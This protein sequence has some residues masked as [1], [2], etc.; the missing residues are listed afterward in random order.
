MVEKLPR[1]SEIGDQID[2]ML[3]K[4]AQDK[5]ANECEEENEKYTNGTEVDGIR[6]PDAVNVDSLPKGLFNI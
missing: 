5:A 4:I 6:L 1:D 2:N 3:S